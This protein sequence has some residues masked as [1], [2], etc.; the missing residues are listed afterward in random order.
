MA[1][2]NG[3]R[4]RLLILDSARS[5]K[6]FETV[7][8]DSYELLYAIEGGEALQLISEKNP[9]LILLNHTVSSTDGIAIAKEIREGGA[10][11]APILLLINE[12]RP[13][14][15]KQAESIGCNGFITKPIDPK[16]LKEKVEGIL[17]SR[18]G[19]TAGSAE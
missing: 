9:E 10:S 15:K 2:S 16:K 17:N 13:T 5:R 8:G 11:H 12:D 7:L 1:R 4:P 19:A 14:L 6:L 3:S 18:N